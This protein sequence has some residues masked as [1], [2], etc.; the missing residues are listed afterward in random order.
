MIGN[1]HPGG[2]LEL[3]GNVLYFHWVMFIG[4]FIITLDGILGLIKEEHFTIEYDTGL[5]K[6]QITGCPPGRPIK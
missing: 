6:I 3:W 4:M 5:L 2:L 1:V